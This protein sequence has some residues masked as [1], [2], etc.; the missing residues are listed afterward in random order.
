LC[1]AEKFLI[2]LPEVGA[3]DARLRLEGL[4]RTVRS[5]RFDLDGVHSVSITLSVG[6]AS[7]P[8]AE[9]ESLEH[10]LTQAERALYQA[11]SQGGDIVCD[12]DQNL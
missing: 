1:G 3:E 8:A 5:Q 9:V 6:F 10:F 2:L 4:R 12:L 11:R 7:R